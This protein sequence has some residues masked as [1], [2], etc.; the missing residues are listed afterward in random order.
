MSETRCVAT[1]PEKSWKRCSAPVVCR[2]SY[3]ASPRESYPYCEKHRKVVLGAY[4]AFV[5]S[6]KR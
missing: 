4:R 6:E 2:I 3:D 1:D 5:I